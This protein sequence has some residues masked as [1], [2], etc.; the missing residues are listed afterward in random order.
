MASVTHPYATV[1][2]SRPRLLEGANAF[3]TGASRGIGRAIA[4]ALA[5]NGANVAINYNRSEESAAEV[6]KRS[7]ENGVKTCIVK[8]DVT[9]VD[10]LARMKREVNASLGIVDV[11][12][13]NAGINMDASF[14]K[15]SLDQWRSVVDTNLTAAFNVTKTFLED[16][17]ASPGRRRIV[18]VASFVGQRGNFGQT[19]YAASKGGIIAFTRA[20]AV[21]LARDNVNVNAVAPGFIETEML[22]G[23]PE[24]VREKL[25]AEIPVRRFGR[26]EDVANAVVFLASPNADYLTGEVLNVNGGIYMG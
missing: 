4:L 12:V 6:A 8:G 16:V 11:L 18:N 25:L 5:E 21:E 26:P 10:D 22:M 20:L 9:S 19:N 2:T 3:V 24:R 13:N 23:V 17:T 7:R 1:S 15:M 14:K